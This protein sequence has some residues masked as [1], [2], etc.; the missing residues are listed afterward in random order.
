MNH[1]KD[2]VIRENLPGDEL[3]I[4]NSGFESR[5]IPTENIRLGSVALLA[6]NMLWIINICLNRNYSNQKTL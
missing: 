3:I 5:A 1:I 6:L 4:W 2:V